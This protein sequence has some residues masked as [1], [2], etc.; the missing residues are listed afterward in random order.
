MNEAAAAPISSVRQ[1]AFHIHAA[2]K[3]RR[4]D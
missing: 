3:Q 1:Q 2:Q 4:S